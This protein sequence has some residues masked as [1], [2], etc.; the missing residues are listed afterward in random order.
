MNLR[1]F[2]IEAKRARL[3]ERA[4]R[5]RGD[6]ADALQ[7]LSQPLGL[8]DRCLDVVRFVVARP[9]LVAGIAIA[10]ALLRP[11]RTLKWARRAFGMWQSYR[12][13]T[14]KTAA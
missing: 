8:V 9:P 14:K 1:L 13:L 2:A 12:W 6:V 4:E 3:M 7:S 10:L 5:Q 11:R